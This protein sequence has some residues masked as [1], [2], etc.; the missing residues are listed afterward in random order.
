MIPAHLSAVLDK[1]RQLNLSLGL[2]Q[3]LAYLTRQGEITMTELASHLSIT[4]SAV[5]HVVDALEKR[6]YAERRASRE[7][8]RVQLISIT[9]AGLS[10]VT[11][12]CQPA[13]A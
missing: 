10:A 4:S 2:M 12:L 9:A 1:A 8:R 13:A 3:A 11:E 5:T 7:D 6:G